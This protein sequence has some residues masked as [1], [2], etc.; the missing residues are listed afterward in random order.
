MLRI[1]V[2]SREQLRLD[3]SNS[4]VFSESV[5]EALPFGDY[6]AEYKN[7]N[8]WQEIPIVFERKSLVDCFGTLTGGYT[9]FK[10]EMKRAKDAGVLF[11]LIIEGSLKTVFEG[12]EYSKFS[13]ESM[14]KKLFTLWVR[15]D[16]IPVF[17]ND[18]DEMRRFIEEMYSAFYR[19][20]EK[21]A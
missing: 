4:H 20:W 15:Y 6:W 8:E 13:G 17:C 12:C 10:N 2:D 19:N 7:A 18:R 14:L 11:I 1:K 16:V 5:V 3:F 21:Q 9:R